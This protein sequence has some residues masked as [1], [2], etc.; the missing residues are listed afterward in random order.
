MSYYILHKNNNIIEI[1]PLSIEYSTIE[2][3]YISNSLFLYYNEMYDEIQRKIDDGVLDTIIPV[4]NDMS[5][6]VY[7]EMTKHI[8]PYEYLFSKVPGSKFSVSKLKPNTNRFYDLLEIYSSLNILDAFKGRQINSL[9]VSKTTN[10]SIECFEML[11]ENPLDNISWFESI[12]DI[13]INKIGN[14]KYDLLYYET[15]GDTLNSYII[16]FI[17]IIMIILK[18]QDI[19][20][21]SIIKIS[22]IFF[23]P[24]VDLIYLLTSLYEKVYIIKPN[25]SNVTTFD[26]YIVCKKFISDDTRIKQNKI[27]YFKLLVLLKKLDNKHIVSIIDYEIP[28]IFKTKLNEIN[29]IIGQQQ[30]E[31]LDQIICILKNKK[32]D[33][34]ETIK[35]MNIQKSVNWCEKHKIPCNK[36]NEKSNIFLPIGKELISL[37]DEPF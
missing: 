3:P 20:G 12:D 25:T 1:K 27:N 31:A 6:N 26:K 13:V 21:F 10:D 29:I 11:R 22:H 23:K 7:E 17:E 15:T 28:Y 24:I 18:N 37:I 19:N 36:F 5:L 32:F 34:I 14:N 33:K 9:H 4:E 30:L 16:S 2:N 8:N 35:K